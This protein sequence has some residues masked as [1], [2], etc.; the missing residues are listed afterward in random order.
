MAIGGII[1]SVRPEDRKD[2]EIILARFAGL[3]VYSADEHGNII[4][5]LD[6]VDAEAVR[7]VI[8][9]ISEL[10]LVQDVR[11]AYLDNDGSGVTCG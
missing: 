7:A 8:E 2:T 9:R 11:L 4:A 3:T 6:E 1:I 10:D 5:R